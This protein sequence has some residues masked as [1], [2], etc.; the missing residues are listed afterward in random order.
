[1]EKIASLQRRMLPAPVSGGFRMEGYWVWCGSVIQGE[2]GRYHMFASRWP[3]SLP[4]H[5][6]WLLQSEVV[7][8]SADAPC[9]PYRF[10][11]VILPGRGPAYWDG[12]MTHNPH[13]T[14][15]GDTYILYYIGSTHPFS[16]PLPGEKVPMTDPRVIVARSNKR[17]GVATAKS[18]FGPW[19]RNDA[20]VLSTRPDHFD[21]FLCSN[22][23]P[24][25]EE[26]GSALLIYKARAYKDPPYTGLLHDKMTFGAAR[27]ERYDA[28]YRPLSDQPIFSPAEMELED[29]FIWRTGDGY[30]MI[31]KDMDGRI[32][33]ERGGGIHA[34]S[35]DGLHWKPQRGERAYSKRVLWD[36]GKARRMGSL[37]RPFLLFERG[38]A[39]H[40]FFATSDGTDSFMDAKNTWNM[41]IPLRQED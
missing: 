18:V 6:G 1:M 30:E 29:P 21:S 14:R 4:M 34:F 33:G 8:A 28:R 19:Q 23:A 7:R 12:R 16:E 41:V 3:K 32:C 15:F 24:C 10:E 31:A 17:I 39:T 20:P 36:D 27:A 38:K 22:P 5:P 2:D 40:A 25:L 9:G 11:E 26:D 35:K 37:E 13:I